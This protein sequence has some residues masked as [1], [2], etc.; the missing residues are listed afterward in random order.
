GYSVMPRVEQA[1]ASYLSPGTALS[2]KAPTLPSKP[3]Q[4][5]LALVGKGYTAVGQAG[6]CLHTMSVLQAYQADLLKKLEEDKEIKMTS[7]SLGEPLICLSAP[8]RR[9]PVPLGG[10]LQLWLTLSDMKEKDRV[11]L[12]D[13]PLGPSGLFV[14][15]VN[16]VVARKQAAVFQWYLP[17]CSL[18]PTPGALSRGLPRRKSERR[19]V[20]YCEAVSTTAGSDG[21]TPTVVAQEQGVLPEGKP[22]SLDQGH[23]AMPTCLG[24]LEEALVP[25]SGPGAGSSLSPC[26]ASDGHALTGWG[27]VISGHPARG[28]WSGP[29]LTL[30]INSLEMLAV[31][32]ALKHFLPDLR[33]RHVLVC[34]NNTAVVYYINH[35]GGLRSRPLYKLAHL[36]PCVVPGQNPLAKGS[37]CPWASQHGSRH[38]VEAGA[39]ARGMDASPQGG[40]AVWRVFDQ[41]QETSQCPL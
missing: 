2:L 39:E 41:A 4:T 12:L 18:T 20:I 13:A 24:H 14:N 5:T 38:P 15:T 11:F 6:A 3:L 29:H 37:S 1:L 8:P 16:S 28:L 32:R 40:E 22:I 30:H 9:P 17:H 33:D 19:P 7:L 10:L 23:A 21:S 27:A 25:V 26:N 35:Q 31:F 34:T 36:D